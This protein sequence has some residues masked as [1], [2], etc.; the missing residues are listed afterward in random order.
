[1]LSSYKVKHNGVTHTHTTRAGNPEGAALLF[2]KAGRPGRALEIA[3][4]AGL[5]GVM[6]DIAAAMGGGEAGGDPAL[7]TR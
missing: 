6:D 7:Q 5:F 1:M 3:Q 2:R 4:A